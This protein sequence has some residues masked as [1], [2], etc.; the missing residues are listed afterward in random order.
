MTALPPQADFDPDGHIW[1]VVVI[2]AGAGGAAA[3]FAIARQGRSVL[4]LERGKPLDQ[5]DTVV[6]G[7]PFSWNGDA[8]AALRH[9][10]WPDPLFRNEDGAET[11]SRLPLGCGTGGSTALYG[12][13]MDRLRRE[14]FT[15][16]RFFPDAPDRLRGAR[17][18]LRRGGAALSRAGHA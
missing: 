10:W 3:G 8:D 11:P 18:V 17:A 4:F 14:D 7:A 13:V 5:D 15:P 12:M 1:D 2:G 6:R 9:G 16:R